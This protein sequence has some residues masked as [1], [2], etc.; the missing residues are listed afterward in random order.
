MRLLSQTRQPDKQAGDGQ[1][2]AQR[3]VSALRRFP[4]FRIATGSS[5]REQQL[6]V[7][8]SFYASF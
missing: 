3:A 8:A 1:A 6:N 4:T 7:P 2:A 5:L